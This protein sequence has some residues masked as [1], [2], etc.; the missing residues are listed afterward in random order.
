MGKTHLLDRILAR[1]KK[2]DGN[3]TVTFKSVYKQWEFSQILFNKEAFEVMH[4]PKDSRPKLDNP[5]MCDSRS[6]DKESY[7]LS[8]YYFYGGFEVIN[9]E[10]GLTVRFSPKFMNVFRFVKSHFHKLEKALGDNIIM[11]RYS[12]TL[13]LDNTSRPKFLRTFLKLGPEAADNVYNLY[14]EKAIKL[15]EADRL[16][17]SD[18]YAIDDVRRIQAHVY[19]AVLGDFK[20]SSSTG[21]SQIYVNYYSIKTT[22]KQSLENGKPRYSSS[23]AP[24]IDTLVDT[25]NIPQLLQDDERLMFIAIS[26]TDAKE[27][28]IETKGETKEGYLNYVGLRNYVTMEK[29]VAA[30][31]SRASGI[32]KHLIE[33]IDALDEKTGKPTLILPS[34]KTV[35]ADEHFQATY[36]GMKHHPV[37]NITGKAGTGKSTVVFSMIAKI[38]TDIKKRRDDGDLDATPPNI[39]LCSFTGKAVKVLINKFAAAEDFACVRGNIVHMTTGSTIRIGTIHKLFYMREQI[40][41]N[42]I[43]IVDETS[44]VDLKTFNLLAQI[45]K[46]DAFQLILVGDPNQLP[47]V[48]VGH[49]YNETIKLFPTYTLMKTHRTS[50]KTIL[51]N[52]N[53]TLG[54][55]RG[56]GQSTRPLTKAG[57]F[58]W[59]R[60]SQ[61]TV[62]RECRALVEKG[63]FDNNL[64]LA[65]RRADVKWMNDY[66]QEAYA[67]KRGVAGKGEKVGGQQLY[68]GDYVCAIKNSYE[69]EIFNGD[70]GIVDSIHLKG[71]TDIEALLG[72]G[73]EDVSSVVT[74]RFDD[75]TVTLDNEEVPETI[76]LAYA[77]TIHKAQGSEVDNVILCVPDNNTAFDAT[78]LYTGETRAKE[79]VKFIS[80]SLNM[81]MSARKPTAAA[82]LFL[83]RRIVKK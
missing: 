13:S 70:R 47:P 31:L 34:G 24:P 23:S 27:P 58:E 55:R 74:I 21:P 19:A 42:T 20:G 78:L 41:D 64:L 75:K 56:D 33:N 77:S 39:V 16:A 51:Y 65:H 35:E 73:Y 67:K 14:F 68:V 44:M 83:D 38:L 22:V 29:G 69:H 49:I 30:F 10:T 28:P 45:C 2:P 54:L 36:S 17:N 81:I 76:T 57:E 82:I 37:I 61:D 3:G 26:M 8:K 11:I 48:S 25:I 63:D 5:F 12:E 53:L 71:V 79:S 1:S 66:V 52:A 50:G 60:Y 9:K 80:K 7:R 40:T 62:E 59:L 72:D 15:D 18:G 43:V 4:I 46:S 32:D 6:E